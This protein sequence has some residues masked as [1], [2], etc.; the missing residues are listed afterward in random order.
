MA[1]KIKTP[2]YLVK[3][4]TIG[5]T[6]PAGFM[7]RENALTAIDVL[8]NE[9]GYNVMIGQTLGN[10]NGTYFSATENERLDE[11]QAMLDAPEINAIL[12]GR[13]GYGVSQFIDQLD[14]TTFKKNPKWI[15]G[16]SDIT[17]LHSTL[18]Q[19]L[20]T[21]SLHAPMCNAF[22]ENK[23][24]DVFVQSL[25]LALAGKKIKYNVVPNSN[26]RK[27]KAEAQLVGGNLSLLAHQTGSKSQLKTDGKILLIEEVGEQ[28]YNADR[29]LIN[30]K[31]SGQLD[32]L[33]GLIIGSFSDPQ[34]TTRPFGKDIYEIILSHVAEFDYPVCFDFA[35]GHTDENYALKLGLNYSLNVGKNVSFKEVE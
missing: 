23:Y 2:P 10:D 27:G 7:K 8:Q 25:K 21:A 4:S 13:G 12:C 15:I 6:C 33:A 30:L 20:Y 32:N 1:R 9:W 24:K 28:L 35:S 14:W 3:G 19:Q 5:I 26:N 17:V 22:N 34:D 29:M 11:F 31:R 16:F 18:H